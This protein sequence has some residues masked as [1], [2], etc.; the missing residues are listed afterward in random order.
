[1][2]T[3]NM[4]ALKFYDYKV[5]SQTLLHIIRMNQTFGAFFVLLQF[6]QFSEVNILNKIIC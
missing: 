1:M 5:K 6:V 4:Q 3:L 2:Y